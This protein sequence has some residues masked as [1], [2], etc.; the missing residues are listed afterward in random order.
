METPQTP[1]T[2][3]QDISATTPL[4]QPYENREFHT[5]QDIPVSVAHVSTGPLGAVERQDHSSW[6]RRSLTDPLHWYGKLDA[7][8]SDCLQKQPVRKIAACLGIGML[9]GML[10]R[11]VEKDV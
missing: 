9:A 11:C 6:K 10:F 8:L 1:S 5:L 7:G 2:T 4:P 3:D